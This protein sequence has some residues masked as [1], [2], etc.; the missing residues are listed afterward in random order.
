MTRENMPSRL[1]IPCPFA[2]ASGATLTPID[3]SAGSTV[4]FEEGFPANYS[5]PVNGKLVSRGEMNAIGNL[6]SVNEFYYR[7]GGINTFDPEWCMANDG[8]PRG[9]V[10]EI[11]EGEINYHKVVSL[12][13]NN[14][15]D[16]NNDTLTQAQINAGI[17]IA[18]TIDNVNWAYVSELDKVEPTVLCSIGNVTATN[19]QSLIPIGGFCAP[20]SGIPYIEGDFEMTYPDNP[21][22]DAEII[23]I[24]LIEGG[25]TASSLDGASIT[26]PGTGNTCTK[27]WDN[28][29]NQNGAVLKAITSGRYYSVWLSVISCGISNS[30]LKLKLS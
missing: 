23:Q 27:I 21:V 18:G 16:F 12:V 5:D 7:A 24:Y 8:Y 1:H 15:V 25:T 17:T 6:A 28:F 22:A 29:S 11:L 9:A 30:E 10:L 2:G 4:N 13:D 20:R 3:V 14:K 19:R 26:S